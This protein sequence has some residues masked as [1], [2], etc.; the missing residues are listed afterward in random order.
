HPHARGACRLDTSKRRPGGGTRATRPRRTPDRTAEP[1]VPDRSRPSRLPRALRGAGFLR[2]VP[3]R[4]C[5]L[6]SMMIDGAVS[7][8]LGLSMAL[9]VTLPTSARAQAELQEWLNPTLGKLSPRTDY[10]FTYYPDQ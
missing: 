2:V 9:L 5:P 4:A 7:R 10:R 3:V 8:C 1:R 6:R